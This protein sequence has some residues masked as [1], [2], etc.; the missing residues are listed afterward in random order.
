MAQTNEST[1]NLSEIDFSAFQGKIKPLSKENSSLLKLD[2]ELRKFDISDLS[3]TEIS[4]SL[5][6]DTGIYLIYTLNNNL[7]LE[8]IIYHKLKIKKY[9]TKM[10]KN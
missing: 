5:D 8:I 3:E 6:N 4:I 1:I 10:I 7:I 2:E 9:I